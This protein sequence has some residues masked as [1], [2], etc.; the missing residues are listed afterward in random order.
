MIISSFADGK[1]TLGFIPIWPCEC[2]DRLRITS[3][4]RLLICLFEKPGHD[5]KRLMRSEVFLIITFHI[6]LL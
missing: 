5:L 3:D 1:I 2:F 4:E 6:Y